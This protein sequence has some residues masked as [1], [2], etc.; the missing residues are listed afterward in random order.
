MLYLMGTL[1]TLWDIFGKFKIQNSKFKIQ[2]SK[3]KPK[4]ARREMNAKRSAN[5]KSQNFKSKLK[6]L[7]KVISI[8]FSEGKIGKSNGVYTKV[9]E[10]KNQTENHP[11]TLE[12]LRAPE[13][14]EILLVPEI[15]ET[16]EAL[17]ALEAPEASETSEAPE[18]LEAAYR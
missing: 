8:K 12:T 2:K 10:D 14:P 9:K 16:S 1:V 15:P 11:E 4:G 13:I 3:A 18:A 6:S 5:V 7:I 17:E